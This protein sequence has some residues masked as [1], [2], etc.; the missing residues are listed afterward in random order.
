MVDGRGDRGDAGAPRTRPR[1][2]R[3]LLPGPR[4]PRSAGALA[5]GL[6]VLTAASAALVAG[7]GLQQAHAAS[8]C[9]GRVADSV[10][11]ST[12][13][14]RVYRGGGKVCAVTLARNP[15]PRRAMSVSLQTR[16][17]R[18]V[19]DAGRFGR[20]AGPVT[21]SPLGRCVRATGTVSG[22]T[23]STGWILC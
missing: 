4:R 17:G 6:A 13:E 2:P 22:V 10:S 16:G 12:G 7:P 11:F 3:P 19:V 1:R 9:P 18:A 23:R 21:V 8:P 14:L 15:G 20:H 5:R